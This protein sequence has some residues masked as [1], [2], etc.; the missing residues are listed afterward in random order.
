MPC[1]KRYEGKLH[2]YTDASTEASNPE[3]A[4]WAAVAAFAGRD[5]SISFQGAVHGRVRGTLAFDAVLKPRDGATP[6]TVAVIWAMVWAGLCDFEEVRGIVW[7]GIRRRERR[8]ES[9]RVQWGRRWW[10]TS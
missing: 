7:I 10:P 6:E 1:K 4:S 3:E 2:M 5:G 8:T 9:L